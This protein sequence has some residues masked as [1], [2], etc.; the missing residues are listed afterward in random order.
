MIP[1]LHPWPI[2][3]IKFQSHEKKLRDII[4]IDPSIQR[5]HLHEL[6]ISLELD[7]KY[8]KEKAIWQLRAIEQMK[9]THA[10]ICFQM[11]PNIKS[12]L[13]YIEVPKD[14]TDWNNILKSKTIQ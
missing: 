4:S 10:S 6:A 5:Q 12:G 8:L 11:K 14:F 7:G 1:I 13:K 2:P 3:Y 9:T